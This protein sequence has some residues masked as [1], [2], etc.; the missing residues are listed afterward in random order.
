M[1]IVALGAAALAAL[2]ST[3]AFAQDIVQTFNGPRIELR[4]GWDNPDIRATLSDNRNRVSR[5]ADKSGFT[6]GGE[7]GYDYSPDNKL[8][9]G[10]YAGVEGSTTKACSE[11][12]GLDRLCVRAGRN[13]TAGARVG[14]VVGESFLVYGK[15]G[16][17]NGRVSVDY[18]DYELILADENVGRNLDG[19][20]V[21]AGV[22][23]ALSGGVYGRLEYVYT[24]YGRLSAETDV[25]SA[26]LKPTRQQVVYAMGVRF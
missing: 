10:G 13:I 2:V 5:S 7:V 24:K 19:F 12:Y 26:S 6:Y 14:A 11:L 4:A 8:V 25:I 18:R 15:G 21:G 23:A 16:Y 22:E 20:H 1:K 17:S 9:I 3:S